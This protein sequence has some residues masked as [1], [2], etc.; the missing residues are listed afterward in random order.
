ME[1]VL[2]IG[3]AGFIGSN[4]AKYLRKEY[5]DLTI[6]SLDNYSSGTIENHI[7]G[8]QYIKGESVDINNFLNP[9]FDIIFHFGEYS[10]ILNSFADS[11]I[12]FESSVKSLYNI[13][14][15]A[16]ESNAK[17][18]YSGSSSIFN[19]Y[20][21][22][23]SP[24]SFFK[25]ISVDII[26]QYCHWNDVDYAICYFYN[27]YGSGEMGDGKYSTVIEKFLRIK[28][29]GLN[30]A[31]VNLPGTQKRIFTH[32]NDVC[33]AL[34]EVMNHCLGDGYM[35]RSNDEFSIL[36]IADKIGLYP[37]FKNQKLGDRLN[38]I[39]IES[40]MSG[41]NWNPKFTLEHYIN[42]RIYSE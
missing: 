4:L 14:E 34:D 28:E 36:D 24:Y 1:R 10:R 15:F 31:P 6:I 21:K 30:Y 40:N 19:D 5:P 41:L 12:V 3:G 29:S 32:V 8:V 16:K 33:T 13:L 11:K 35:I 27:V 2:I 38:P 39:E 7:D 25:K 37:V 20:G 26:N 23:I 9:C 17:M 22:D 42:E 18:I